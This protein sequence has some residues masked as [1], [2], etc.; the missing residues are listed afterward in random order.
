MTRSVNAKL[1]GAIKLRDL[2]DSWKL[3]AELLLAD[4]MSSNR[5]SLLARPEH[6]LTHALFSR[7]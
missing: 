2:S 6:E 3:D 1:E 4:A 5:A 7:P